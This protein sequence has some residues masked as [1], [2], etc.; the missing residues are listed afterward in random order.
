MAKIVARLERVADVAKSALFVHR[1]M[2][3]PVIE[4]KNRI[5]NAEPVAEFLLFYNDH[6]EVAAK[7]QGLLAGASGLGL[8]RLYE[9]QDDEDSSTI[10]PT[11]RREVTMEIVNNILHGFDREVRRQQTI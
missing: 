3:M 9:L 2:G 5:Q 8:L 6:N 4:A 7:L 11:D 1:L 10:G